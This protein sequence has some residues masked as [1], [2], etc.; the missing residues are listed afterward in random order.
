MLNLD[1]DKCLSCYEQRKVFLFVK[2]TNNYVLQ[3]FYLIGQSPYQKN[4]YLRRRNCLLC[5]AVYFFG[6]ILTNEEEMQTKVETKIA[7]SIFEKIR[8]SRNFSKHFRFRKHLREHRPTATLFA[9]IFRKHMLVFLFSRKL[10]R[11]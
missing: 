4:I 1:C 7:F 8:I 11:K 5:L 6:C 3:Y 10:S 9:N 2:T